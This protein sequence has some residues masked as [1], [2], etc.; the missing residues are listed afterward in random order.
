MTDTETAEHKA[1][2]LL[3]RIGVDNAWSFSSGE[4]VELA[5]L[6]ADSAR[7]QAEIDSLKNAHATV[8]RLYLSEQECRVANQDAVRN[9][10]DKIEQLQAEIGRLNA[11]NE[12]QEQALED[13]QNACDLLEGNRDINEKMALENKAILAEIDR[14]RGERDTWMASAA[15]YGADMV[16]WKV[17]AQQAESSLSALREA[18]VWQPIKT[19]PEVDALLLWVPGAGVQIGGWLPVSREW[20]WSDRDDTQPTHWMPLPASPTLED[21]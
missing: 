13:A 15:G 7:Q 8:Q 21:R 17:L 9:A 4:V 2:A 12:A 14:L 18:H 16:E 11:E 3:D 20:S 5:N 1:R 6:I 10:A 19:A